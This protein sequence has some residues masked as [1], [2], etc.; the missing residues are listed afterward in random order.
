MP[1]AGAAAPVA[2]GRK[3][4]HAEPL[5]AG[6]TT[7]SAVLESTTMTTGI[8]R[9]C[10][11]P[12]AVVRDLED[13]VCA[14]LSSYSDDSPLQTALRRHHYV[15]AAGPPGAVRRLSPLEIVGAIAYRHQSRHAGAPPK[16]NKLAY[17]LAGALLELLGLP[18]GT[19]VTLHA[20]HASVLVQ[21]LLL[22]LTAGL[23]AATAASTKRKGAHGDE[24][25]GPKFPR[26]EGNRHGPSAGRR[27]LPPAGP[28]LG[29]ASTSAFHR[30]LWASADMPRSLHMN[31]FMPDF[32]LYLQ[33][34]IPTWGGGVSPS[35]P[36]PGGSCLG[37]QPPPVGS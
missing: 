18:S 19:D 23:C 17:G 4:G 28:T 10:L 22:S 2:P 21:R 6:P 33:E 32:M 20:G 16:L 29:P 24:L 11:L 34:E 8:L 3:D 12:V 7:S 14:G 31:D 25:S 26:V 15:P 5:S 30:E 36:R 9:E 13:L 35:G 27:L 1:R 37:A